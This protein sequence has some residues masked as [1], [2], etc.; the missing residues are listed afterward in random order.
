MI[1]QKNNIIGLITFVWFCVV[2]LEVIALKQRVYVD[3]YAKS[4]EYDKL[5]ERLEKLEKLTEQWN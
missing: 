2:S 1:E 5:K 3:N 4:V